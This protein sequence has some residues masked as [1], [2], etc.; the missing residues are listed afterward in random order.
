VVADDPAMLIEI[1]ALDRSFERGCRDFVDFQGVGH[2]A[3]PNPK[4][5][6]IGRVATSAYRR[7]VARYFRAGDA[8]VVRS[9]YTEVY[10]GS[11]FMQWLKS[12]PVIVQA[13]GIT[14]YAGP[15]R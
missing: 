15:G 11:E 5:Y 4:A 1:N 14:V 10:L 6:V 12:Q 8:I 13:G 7:E 9:G 3:G 2:G